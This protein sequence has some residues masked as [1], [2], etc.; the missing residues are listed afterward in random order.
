M[1]PKMEARSA[2]TA[3][4]IPIHRRAI[5]KVSHPPHTDGGGMKAN[6][7]WTKH[8]QALVAVVGVLFVCFFVCLCLLHYLFWE[9]SRGKSGSFSSTRT[10]CHR[11]ALPGSP[12][13]VSG[14]CN[15]SSIFS[16]PESHIH[17]S[18]RQLPK[19]CRHACP[20]KLKAQ[21]RLR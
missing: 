1:Q 11:V 13:G 8:T 6:K 15:Y 4:N 21:V 14:C 20:T 5:P 10:S 2:M 19:N 16:R 3:V 17:L 18:A 9:S 12:D 7:T